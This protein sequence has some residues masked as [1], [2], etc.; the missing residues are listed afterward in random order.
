MSALC[1]RIPSLVNQLRIPTF[2]A[3][4]QQKVI[5]SSLPTRVLGVNLFSTKPPPSINDKLME[6]FDDPKNWEQD[7]IKTGRS[8]KLDELRIKSNEDLHKLW[9]VLLKERNMLLTMERECQT[10]YRVF[11]NP[12][13]IDKVEESMENLETVVRER[14]RAYFELETTEPAER[15]GKLEMNQIG[16]RYFYKHSEHLIPKVMNR[17]WR[18]KVVHGYEGNAV[19]KFLRL[20][21]EKLRDRESWKTHS[22]R[23]YV[24]R[25]FSEYPDADAKSLQ[26]AFPDVDVEAARKHIDAR[27]NHDK[28]LN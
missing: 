24:S 28:N 3:L 26:E 6:F 17:K 2:A 16:M 4:K 9:Y 20:K 10:E 22:R 13:R 15:P 11:P 7:N 18:E 21:A 25:I 8:W 19:K 14:N 5:L 27:G 23:R 12:E 1:R